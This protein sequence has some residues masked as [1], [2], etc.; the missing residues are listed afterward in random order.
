MG[1]QST[2]QVIQRKGNTRQYY[3]ICPAALAEALEIEKGEP[4]EWVVERKDILMLK[5]V[6]ARKG[7]VRS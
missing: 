4:F 3:L 2:M 5:R 1:Y 6:H 7:K